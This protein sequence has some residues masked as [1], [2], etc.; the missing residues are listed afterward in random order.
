MYIDNHC[1]LFHQSKDK[2]KALALIEDAKN[3]GLS[4][5]VNIG[6]KTEEFAAIIDLNDTYNIEN[7]KLYSTLG[8]HPDEIKNESID[9]SK[10][11]KYLNNQNIIAIGECGFDI[12]KETTEDDIKLQQDFFVFQ[13]EL[14]IK[15][16]LP[17]NIHTRNAQKITIET[18]KKYQSQGITGC[19]HCFSG[20]LNF[21][22]EILDLGFYISFSGIVTFKNAK[23]V[24]EVAKNI[25]LE[26]ILT[27]TDAPFLAP[28]PF[29]GKENKP[30]YVEYTAKYISLLRGI[31][32]DDFSVQ[33]TKNFLNL[34][35][36]NDI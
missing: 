29:R 32:I 23:D 13:I 2:E 9:E 25:P 22:K 3:Q 18:L 36:I 28:M 19:I 17:L 30:S 27:E 1:H 6:T 4:H 8:I 11:S 16:K 21:A 33:I 31:S 5:L 7:I 35:K 12:D 26:Y 24:Q 10:F 15:N 20:D 14:A 34:Y